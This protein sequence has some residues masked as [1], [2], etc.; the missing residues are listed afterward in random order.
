MV[1]GFLGC[2]NVTPDRGWYFRVVSGSSS[3]WVTSWMVTLETLG[4]EVE[5]VSV[6]LGKITGIDDGLVSSLGVSQLASALSKKAM[7]R[8]RSAL[9]KGSIATPN[10]VLNQ[11]QQQRWLQWQQGLER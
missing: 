2:L 8:Y 4:L 10:W 1:A 9:S 6:V 5:G 11:W 7:T 3:P